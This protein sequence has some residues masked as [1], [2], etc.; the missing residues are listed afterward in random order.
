M[1][2][3]T[4]RLHSIQTDMSRIQNDLDKTHIE[5]KSKASVTDVRNCVLRSHFDEVVVTLGE[6][7]D[8]KASD[9]ELQMLQKDMKVWRIIS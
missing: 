3:I 7:L 2:S 1:K 5:V 6:N 4:S 8:A 9:S